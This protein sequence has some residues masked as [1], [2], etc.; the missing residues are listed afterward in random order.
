MMAYHFSLWPQCGGIKA[1]S[2]YEKHQEQSSA[3]IKEKLG[4]DIDAFF[5]SGGKVTEVQAGETGVDKNKH[6]GT[7]K[8]KW[9]DKK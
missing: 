5:K 2:K 9:R 4:K 1:M 6:L 8:I 3:E 7:E